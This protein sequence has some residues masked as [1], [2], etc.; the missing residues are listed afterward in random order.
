[1]QR[2]VY[3]QK[4]GRLKLDCLTLFYRIICGSVFFLHYFFIYQLQCLKER[5]TNRKIQLPGLVMGAKE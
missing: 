3:I 4:K 1:L 5:E 2:T